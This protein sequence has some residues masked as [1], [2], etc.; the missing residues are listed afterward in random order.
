M[1]HWVAHKTMWLPGWMVVCGQPL[2][3]FRLGHLRL[4]E[5]IESPF[6]GGD[7]DAIVGRADLA[8]AVAALRL[9]WRVALCLLR[10]PRAWRWW[11]SWNV[12]RVKDWR[13]EAEAL[14]VYL[15]DCLWAPEAYQEQGA[16]SDTSAFGYASSF[17]MRV[18]WRLSEGRV[19][20]LRAA[21]WDMSIIEALAW[22]V[23]SAEMSGRGFVTRDEVEQVEAMVAAQVEHEAAAA[24]DPGAE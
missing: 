13:A 21:V 4:L 15:D 9:P 22:A 1:A 20:T 7:G 2:A 11:A 3:P 6:L 17:A 19:P 16:K 10:H 18:A 24:Q 8:Q 14:S 5:I 12:R 23:T